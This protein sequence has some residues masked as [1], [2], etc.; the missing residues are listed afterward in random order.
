M[1]VYQVTGS[2]VSSH[3][4][5][6]HTVVADSAEEA[7]CVA[8]ERHKLDVHEVRE[9]DI[10][11]HGRPPAGSLGDQQHLLRILERIADSK[12][13]R[14]PIGTIALGIIIGMLVVMLVGF[15]VSLTLLPT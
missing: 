5:Q 8:N 15:L 3:D 13:I 2:P 9:I 10:H 11:S 14:E 12:L 7:E 1:P 4:S 6:T